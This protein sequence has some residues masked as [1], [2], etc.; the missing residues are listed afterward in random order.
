MPNFTVNLE[1]TRNEIRGLY[2]KSGFAGKSFA[3]ASRWP[4][5]KDQALAEQLV[6]FLEERFAEARVVNLNAPYEAIFLREFTLPFTDKDKVKDVLPFEIEATVPYQ[7]EE[8][9]YDTLS[10]IRGNET[11]VIVAGCAVDLLLPTLKELQNVGISIGS[12]YVPPYALYQF[13]MEH[14]LEEAMVYFIERHTSIFL[15]WEKGE[16]PHMRIMPLG[17]E[18]LIS[19]LQRELSVDS[20]LAWEIFQRLSSF[21]YAEILEGDFLKHVKMNRKEIPAVRRVVEEFREQFLREVQFFRQTLQVSK[22]DVPEYFFCD[23]DHCLLLQSLLGKS[24]LVVFPYEETPLAMFPKEMLMAMAAGY[25]TQQR[26]GLNLLQGKLRKEAR[27]KTTLRGKYFFILLALSFLFFVLSFYFDFRYRSRFLQQKQI[28]A[29]RIFESYF[30]MAPTSDNI[31][32]E[33]MLLVEKER[34]KTEIFRKFFTGEKFSQTL[35]AL[36]QNLPVGIGLEIES[37]GYDTKTLEL[38]GSLPSFAALNEL[39]TALRN[40]GRFDGVESSR[41]KSMPSPQGN[42]IKFSLIIK[43]KEKKEG[44][45]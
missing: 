36:H 42:R 45:L 19:S 31:V 23:L 8:I 28:E 24:N 44:A 40:S 13:A 4:L 15:Y 26:K 3:Q 35:V 14:N 10:V 7:L 39:K 38:S 33:A 1:I 18:R 20:Q 11:K 12:I 25:A 17:Y 30:G 27:V 22:E 43:P 37:I 9:T 21:N 6:R 16:L 34:R 32:E 29:S 2:M 41:E 5:K